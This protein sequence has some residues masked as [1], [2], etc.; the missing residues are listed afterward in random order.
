M[1]C[2]MAIT[3]IQTRLIWQIKDQCQMRAQ[4]RAWES[5][6]VGVRVRETA[7]IGMIQKERKK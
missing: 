3:T 5:L 4:K 1:D 6:W 7:A 2:S